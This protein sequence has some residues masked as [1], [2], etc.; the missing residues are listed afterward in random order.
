MPLDQTQFNHLDAAATSLTRALHSENIRYL[1]L[2]GYATGLIGGNRITE[3]VDIVTEIDCRELL[4]KRPGFTR[5][6]DGRLAYDYRGTKVYVDVMGPNN[7]TW[8]IP[9]P[10]AT[11]VYNVNPEDRPGRRLNTSMSIVHP[12]VLV[13]TKLKCWSTAEM[14]TR[15]AYHQRARTDL[16]DILT[17]LRWLEMN[18]LT[19]NFAGLS[20]VPKCE[21]LS[22]LP[23]L[24]WTQKEVRPHLAATLTPEELRDVLNTRLAD[25]EVWSL[26][27]SRFRSGSSGGSGGSGRGS[28]KYEA[29]LS[30]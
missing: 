1:F 13:L 21:L 17:I 9:D 23:K 20:R 8:H 7:R 30:L 10:R 5:S 25:K 28:A 3:D 16:Q 12:S 29:L 11:Q 22:F 27:S 19:I 24:Y 6:T 26:Y 18:N 2:G 15:Q 4:L 14:A